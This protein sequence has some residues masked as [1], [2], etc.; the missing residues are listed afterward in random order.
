MCD[1]AWP[2][3]LIPGFSLHRGRQAEV[4]LAPREDRLLAQRIAVSVTISIFAGLSF[5]DRPLISVG[6]RY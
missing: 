4:S 6:D 5:I 2:T 1:L 3:W